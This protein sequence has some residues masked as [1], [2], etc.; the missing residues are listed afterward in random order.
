AAHHRNHD[1]QLC[2]PG[3]SAGQ[4]HSARGNLQALL[5]IHP[6]ARCGT[7]VRS[8]PQESDCGVE[9]DSAS[10]CGG[11]PILPASA[12]THAIG[13]LN[14][15]AMP[16]VHSPSAVSARFEVREDGRFDAGHQISEVDVY[17]Y[18]GINQV[19]GVLTEIRAVLHARYPKAILDEIQEC[20]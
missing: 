10:T 16:L 13:T 11:G 1:G 12:C 14:N 4:A 17:R 7:L 15:P 9:N 2:L 5:R 19:C 18:S 8:Q 3:G 20:H 6:G